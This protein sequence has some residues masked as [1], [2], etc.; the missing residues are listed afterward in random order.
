MLQDEAYRTYEDNI[1]ESFDGVTIGG[2]MMELGS[3]PAQLQALDALVIQVSRC[4]DALMLMLM[5]TA[6]SSAA[7]LSRLHEQ[8]GLM[9]PAISLDP[10]LAG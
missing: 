9:S 10:A 6:P 7:N 5:T 1:L 2:G 4:Y 3:D 8:G